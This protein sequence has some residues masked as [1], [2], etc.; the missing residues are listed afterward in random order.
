MP[1][2]PE[3]ETI[4]RDLSQKILH[5]KI[6]KVEVKK[7]RIVKGD[8]KKFVQIL[9][10]NKFVSLGRV[11]KL[12]ILTLDRN[13]YNLLI[14]LKMTGQ[15]IYC[16]QGHFVAGGHSLPKI[17]D[18][19]PNKYS[20][21][22][23]TFADNSR[24]FFNDMRQF[25]YLQLVNQSELDKITKKYGIEPLTADFKPESLKQIVKKRTAPIKAVLLN[26][27]L[28]SGIGN[29]YADEILFATGI[30]PTRKA[31]TL[32]DHEIKKI[33]LASQKIIKAA[34]KFRGTTFNDYVDADGNI[35]SFVKFLKVYGRKDKKCPRCKGIVKKIKVAGR[36]THYC[37]ACQK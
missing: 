33:F 21:V 9:V 2:L 12:L 11:G 8:T 13:K 28:I 34:I 25:G 30:R 19:L 6:T 23:F 27:Q 1:E 20:H 18:S 37:S 17:G 26:Q 35:G 16:H 29:I 24:L 7:K 32:S 31:S 14:H 10:G 36:G 3:V 22:I 5:K 15:L 4:R